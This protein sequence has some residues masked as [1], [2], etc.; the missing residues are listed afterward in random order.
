MVRRYRLRRYADGWETNNGLN[1]RDS[2][3]GDDDPDMDGWDRDGDGSAVYEE[4]IFNTRVT[5]IKKTIGETV[6]E[7]ETVVRA[8]YTKAGGQTEP[9]N[10][11]LHLL[12]L[13]IRCMFP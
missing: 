3:N 9:V 7:G 13:F 1:P 10:I 6:A 4:L 8:E 2:S 5:Q 12:V 11:K